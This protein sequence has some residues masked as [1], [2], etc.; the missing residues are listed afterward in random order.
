MNAGVPTQVETA[1]SVL[2]A[3]QYVL[4]Q[5]FPNPFNPSTSIRYTL[6]RN[7]RVDLE[8]FNILGERVS[9]LVQEEQARGGHQITF[10]AGG[11]PSGIYFCRLRTTEGVLTRRMVLAR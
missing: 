4:E 1:G 10:D 11:L 8:V 5:N 9:R 7:A 3:G 2:A 6:P